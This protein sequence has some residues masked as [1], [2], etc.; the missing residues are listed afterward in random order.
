[1]L[2]WLL[3]LPLTIFVKSNLGDTVHIFIKFGIHICIYI[4]YI[5]IYTYVYIN[6]YIYIY[7]Y[8]F[9]YIGY[10]YIYIYGNMFDIICCYLVNLQVDSSSSS[11]PSNHLESGDVCR[12]RLRCP[13]EYQ[14]KNRSSIQHKQAQKQKKTRNGM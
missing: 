3:K 12:Q 10:V 7:T 6:M 4:I 8:I 11:S 2:E 13:S 5:Y 14:H 9:I 1:M